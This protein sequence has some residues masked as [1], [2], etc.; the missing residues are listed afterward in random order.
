MKIGITGAGGFLGF[1]LRAFLY[2]QGGHEVR[3]ATR[4]TFADP[5]A[6][7][8]FVRDLGGVA[9]FAG[10]NRGDEA[11]LEAANV[12]LASE[13]VTAFRR[14]GA[15]PSLVFANSIHV[16]RETG[17]GRGKRAA[18]ERL[19]EWAAG[20]GTAFADF[21]LPNVFGEFGRPFYNS[22]VATFCHQL[23]NGHTPEIQVD[24]KLELLH[25]QVV[26]SCF[27]KALMQGECG[28]TRLVGESRKVS[29]LLDR[30]RY[31][32]D[33]YVAAKVIPD[34]S[35]PLNLRLFNTL[36]SY[37]YPSHYPVSLDLRSDAR[38]SLFEAVKVMQGGQ[39]FLST[40]HPGITRGNHY[41]LRKVERFL[42]VSGSAEIR[43]RKLFS[44]DMKTF[45]VSGNVPCYVDMQAVGP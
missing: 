16:E 27:A 39:T 3:L 21:V 35:D 41:H 6:L 22:V 25:A 1:H 40:S 33:R 45:L 13:L 9:H 43:V 44:D 4:E 20:T 32:R 26:A 17:Y 7:D 38:G 29:E 34:L 10:M 14:T 12:S 5:V 42:V 28:T 31:M 11:S 30:L 8:D 24:A 2:A 37:L 18:A 36:R 19:A 23:A 15:R